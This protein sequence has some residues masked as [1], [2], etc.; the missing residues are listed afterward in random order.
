M[1]NESL[2]C[3]SKYTKIVKIEIESAAYSHTHSHAHNDSIRCNA[4]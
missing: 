4:C 1:N 2:R 3:L